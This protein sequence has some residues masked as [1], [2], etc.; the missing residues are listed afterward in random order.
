MAE[1]IYLLRRTK[2]VMLGGK[3]RILLWF[4]KGILTRRGSGET[5]TFLDDAWLH[6][7]ALFFVFVNNRVVLACIIE[8]AYF[9]P[10]SLESLGVTFDF[11]HIH[12]SS[13]LHEIALNRFKFKVSP[14]TT[15]TVL[16]DFIHQS[17]R[18]QPVSRVA[19]RLPLVPSF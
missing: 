19:G 15:R 16:H 1:A 9:W 3:I 17:R 10:R 14:L 6:V 2:E 13:T 11:H 12:P 7:R 8:F 18:T 5:Q 4:L